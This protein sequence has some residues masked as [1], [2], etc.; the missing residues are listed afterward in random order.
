MCKSSGY[1]QGRSA[2]GCAS[3]R[4]MR[5]V[6]VLP[7]VQVLGICAR[8]KCSP[9]CKFSEYREVE[10]L[11]CVQGEERRPDSARQRCPR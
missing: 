6:E 4:N 1:A 11:P 10:V 9:M 8:S 7:D 5:E 3:S 2:P